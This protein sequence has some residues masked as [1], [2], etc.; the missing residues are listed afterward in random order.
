MNGRCT[1]GGLALQ[2]TLVSIALAALVSPLG[3]TSRVRA[4]EAAAEQQAQ[5]EAQPEAQTSETPPDPRLTE[6]MERFAA[7]Q[8]V[9]DAG[10]YGAALAEFERI[11][12]LLEGHPRR[13]FVLYN[14]GRCHE[15]LFRY[16][17]AMEAYRRYLDEGGPSADN[18][19]VVQAT[20]TTLEGLLATVHVD[21]NV[22][23]AEVWIGDRLVG[24]APGD[25]RIPAGQH[26]VEVR[27]DGYT[28]SRREITLAA[29]QSLTIEVSL[30]RVSDFT[31]LDP[32]FFITSAAATGVA[33]AV[34]IGFGVALLADR[35][36]AISLLNSG[37][38]ADRF[39]V[40]MATEAH[41]V[42]LATYADAF[43][44][45]ALGLAVVTVVVG[46]LTDWD[47]PGGGARP[48][49]SSA[50]LRFGAS[51]SPDGGASFAIGGSF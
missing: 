12:D 19:A 32:A 47:G 25:I 22:E 31:G 15:Q 4:Q 44:A 27:A 36:A 35:S 18:Y 6:A 48:D 28:S 51:A 26:A 41:L 20:I 38:M 13:H 1:S 8:R 46:A 40:T 39:R 14:I 10:D 37:D 42:E 49:S 33:L 5:P 16:D 3:V 2:W 34:G 29:R 50:R 9:F 43:Y 45:T 24:I 11:Y 23:H 7:A 30:S 17:L 21:V